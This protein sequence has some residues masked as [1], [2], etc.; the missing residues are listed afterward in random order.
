MLIHLRCARSPL[1]GSNRE[2]ESLVASRSDGHLSIVR[3]RQSEFIIANE[4]PAHDFEPWVTAWDYWDTNV[5][6]S[7]D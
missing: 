1:A 4:W 7:G 6:Y 3:P 2:T 5:I